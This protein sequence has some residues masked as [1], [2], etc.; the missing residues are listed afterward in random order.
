MKNFCGYFNQGICRSCEL[1]PSEYPEQ[2]TRKE[3]LLKDSLARLGSF[4]LLPTQSSK[5]Q[6][7][8]NK[9]KMTVSGTIENPIIGLV[10][11]RE[12]LSCPVHHEKINEVLAGCPSRRHRILP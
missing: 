4:A 9:A 11:E 6:G 8:R 5:I 12:I 10:G 3:K 1:L 2:I 7:F